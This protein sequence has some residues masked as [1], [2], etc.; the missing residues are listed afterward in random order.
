[1]TVRAAAIAL[2]LAVAGACSGAG[3]DTTAIRVL[4]AAS[5]TDAFADVAAAFEE[6]SDGAVD[7]ELSFAGS[8]ALRE[9]VLAGAPADVL[10][11]VGDDDM[12]VVVAAGE[13]GDP[14]T[15]ATNG[16]QVAVPA[17][18]R[19]GVTG[20][21][22]LA[23]P[24]L[25]VG[26]CAPAVPCGSAARAAFDAAG[27]VPSVDTEE[28]DVRALLAKLAGGELDAGVVYRTDV[29]VAGGAVTGIDLP[30]G[31]DTAVVLRAAVLGGG[32]D[33]GVGGD[34]VAFLLSPGGQA[35][36]ADHGFGPP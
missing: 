35:I 10:A 34:F 25:L 32:A 8:P 4:A 12:A 20:L 3:D 11:T 17:A 6:G 26:V 16:L 24:G 9:S 19:G 36:L 31:V 7:V 18:N 15:F 1:M 22:D 2:T 5:L 21:G 30:A 23:R 13:A 33:A 28:P 14:V 27:V 29:L